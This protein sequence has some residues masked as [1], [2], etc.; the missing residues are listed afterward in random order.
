MIP[1]V[2]FAYNRPIHLKKCIESLLACKGIENTPLIIYCDGIKDLRNLKEVE[3]ISIV[4]D[5]VRNLYWPGEKSII[6]SDFNKGLADSIITGLDLVFQKYQSA[7]ILEDDLIV[8]VDFLNYMKHSLVKYSTIEKVKQISAYQFPINNIQVNNESFFLPITNT[9][10]WATWKRVWVEVNFQP[11]DYNLLQKNQEMRHRFNIQNS[12]N[13][14]GMLYRQMRDKKFGS[15]GIRFYWHVFKI[16][17]LTL[18]PDYSLVQHLDLNYSGTH[19]TNF[20]QFNYTNWINSYN[21]NL[22]P[23]NISA[24]MNYMKLVV[25]FLK[26]RKR[27]INFFS[28]I[29]YLFIKK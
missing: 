17:G 28:K 10:G 12:Y 20:E 19:P 25:E 27:T 2:I 14:S 6:E 5:L 23:E 29:K 11:N 3:N 15:W 13:Y 8:G 7:I 9:W 1:V 4:R 21:I 18:Y 26:T 16:D 22:F 24:H